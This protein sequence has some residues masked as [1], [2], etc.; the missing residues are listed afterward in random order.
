M[1]K[2][3]DAETA[4]KMVGHS[5]VEMTEYYTRA[6]IPEMVSSIQNVLQSVNELFN[7]LDLTIAKSNV[8]LNMFPY[9][10]QLKE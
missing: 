5:S 9:W 4:K 3:V 8:I 6:A 10:E 7:Q 1:R 2:N